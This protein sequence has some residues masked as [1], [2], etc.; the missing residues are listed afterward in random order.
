MF[1]FRM[2]CVLAVVATASLTSVAAAEQDLPDLS[3]TCAAAA[4]GVPDS[5]FEHLLVTGTAVASPEAVETSVRC[6]F[7]EYH[8]PI[9]GGGSS[10]WEAA[11]TLP[12]PV[13]AAA[14]EAQLSTYTAQSYAL[15]ASGSARWEDG[16]VTELPEQCCASN[17]SLLTCSADRTEGT[18]HFW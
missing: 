4:G 8:H 6:V 7:V 5:S 18:R 15:C 9:Y 3:V 14:R 16:Q 1:R 10:S 12:G 17:V 13:A 11:G 2:T